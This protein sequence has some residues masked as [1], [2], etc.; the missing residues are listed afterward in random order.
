MKAAVLSKKLLGVPVVTQSRTGFLIA[1]VLGEAISN[2]GLVAV[3]SEH[4]VVAM[5]GQ[6]N[7]LALRK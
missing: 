4:G 6:A 3:D 2:T 7:A 1:L 5:E